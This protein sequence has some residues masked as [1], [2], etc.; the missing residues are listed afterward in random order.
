MSKLPASIV[1]FDVETTGLHSHDRIVTLGA[2][3][4]NTAELS[5]DELSVD[6]LHIIVDPG[7]K[8]HPRA[9]EVHGYSDWTLRHQQP[10]SEHAESVRGFLAGGDVI[11]AHNASFD[12]GFIKREYLALG[13]TASSLQCYCTMN[14]YRLAGLPGRAS[15]NAICREMGLSRVGKK[16]GALEDAWLALMVYFWL[17]RA[18]AKFI[19][20]FTE[21]ASE[22]IPLI[23][24]NFREPPP[25]PE[26]LV[27]TRRAAIVA[28]ARELTAAR[29]AAKTALL[30]AVRPTAIL[31]LEVARASEALAS[32]EIEILVALIRATRDRLALSADDEI[33]QEVLAELFDIKTTQNQLTRSA[34]ALCDDSASRYEFP[35]WLATMATIDG[36]VSEAEREA[37]NRVKAAINRVLS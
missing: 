5:G 17:H 26:G 18:P 30:K 19:R 33:E 2:W 36:T 15:L 4:V 12:L 11:V 37:I 10:F 3:R 29:A 6:C 9:E 32:E 8:S 27:P 31:L 22:G 35:K 16:H 7:R 28:K 34:R 23:P 14:G 21:M 20:P 25:L 24:H 13:T 1:A